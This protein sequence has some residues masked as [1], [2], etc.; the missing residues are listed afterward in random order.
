MSI[1]AWLCRD[2]IE[3]AFK[4]GQRSVLVTQVSKVIAT[5][6]QC[7]EDVRSALIHLGARKHEADAAVQAAIEFD[8]NFDRMFMAAQAALRK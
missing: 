5:N 7:S 8:G 4:A 1:R 6:S 3:A 2:L